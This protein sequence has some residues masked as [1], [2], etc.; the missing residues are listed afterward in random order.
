MEHR[1]TRRTFLYDIGKKIGSDSGQ[2][3]AAKISILLGAVLALKGC[4][5]TTNTEPPPAK[6]SRFKA[7]FNGSVFDNTQ[8]LFSMDWHY[9]PKLFTDKVDKVS[10]AGEVLTGKLVFEINGQPRVGGSDS[11]RGTSVNTGD[12]ISW[13]DL[14]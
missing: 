7:T 9:D 2:L 10:G 1:V 3:L 11:A 8:A 4:G 6:P 12:I 13:K 5:G 14:S